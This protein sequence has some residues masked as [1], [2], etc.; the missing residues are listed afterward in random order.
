MTLRIPPHRSG[1]QRNAA[2]AGVL[3]VLA[4]IYAARG[5]ASAAE[6][7]ADS[8][9]CRPYGALRNIDDAADRLGNAIAQRER[10]VI[11]ADYDADGATAC[12][13]GVRGLRAMGADV[14]YHRART[15]SSTA[16]A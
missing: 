3:P 16:T 14:D 7:D 8:L 1:H 4:R 10:I 12:A 11:V 9:R 2:A 5:I 15:A 13:V 6:L